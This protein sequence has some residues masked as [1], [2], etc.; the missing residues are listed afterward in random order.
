M[1][2]APLLQ[3]LMTAFHKQEAFLPGQGKPELR[4][5]R[6]Q[7][8]A[9]AQNL[10]IP[11]IR[12]DAWKHARFDT[13]I[14]HNFIPYIHA[15]DKAI[16]K[17][18]AHQVTHHEDSI[19]I[20]F[21]NGHYV[22]SLSH[23]NHSPIRLQSLARLAKV[24]PE[25]LLDF[26]DTKRE[27]DFFGELNRALCSDGAVVII[28]EELEF[29]K[30]VKIY[31]F[32]VNDSEQSSMIHPQTYIHLGKNS[33]AAIIEI[34][35]SLNQQAY[36]LFN[37]QTRVLCEQGADCEFTRLTHHTHLGL[38]FHHLNAN[39]L[40]NSQLT[41]TELAWG[42]HYQRHTLRVALKEASA[43]LRCHGLMLPDTYEHCDWN[44]KVTHY[45]TS[46]YSEQKIKSVIAES[47]HSSFL[48]NIAVNQAAQ[49]TNT[50]MVNENL[51]LGEKGQADSAPQLEILADEVKCNHAATIT[52]LD[53]KALFYL[54]SRGFSQDAA[55]L[56]LLQAFTKEVVHHIKHPAVLEHCQQMVAQRVA[57]L[58][59][60][61][62][63][64]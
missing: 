12:Q 2:S 32:L 30:V 39:L 34:N 33:H 21:L 60:G 20:V 16:L 11:S 55:K 36:S 54:L 24:Q 48:G 29:D 44:S 7:A 1:D 26:Q 17:Q 62:H 40:E 59:R 63:E 31:H 47:G 57:Q 10:G 53:D 13:L 25:L 50:L 4:A 15:N 58:L 3:H 56:L 37:S 14:N 23:H 19:N 28:P 27:L 42:A 51:L 6:H 22:P 5:L 41:L 35:T 43:T 8:M 45:A 49:Q 18:I 61:S 38:G 64:S 52:Q 9:R 46:G